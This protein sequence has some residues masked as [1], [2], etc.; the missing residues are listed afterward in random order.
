MFIWGQTGKDD[1]PACPVFVCPGVSKKAE[2]IISDKRKMFD[3]SCF[4]LFILIFQI[5][6]GQSKNNQ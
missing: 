1:F 2:C 5:K 4:G 3:S 6:T